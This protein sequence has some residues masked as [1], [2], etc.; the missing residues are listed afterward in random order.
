MNPEGLTPFCHPILSLYPERLNPES[1]WHGHIPF[2]FWITAA[3]QPQI[4]VEL[5]VY[6]ADSY[7]AFC[8]A[9]KYL[10]YPT[11]CYGID[12]WKGDE[13]T[14]PL[15]REQF[16]ELESY[17]YPRY[18]SFS[19]LLSF[20]FDEALDYFK[21]SSIDLLHIDGSSTYPSVRHNFEK[22][23]PKM[24]DR[25]IILIHGTNAREKEFGSWLYWEE[26]KESYPHFNFL[27]GHGLG[28]LAVGKDI[29]PSLK[30]LLS[31][32]KEE[33]DIVRSFFLRLG[34]GVAS[35]A[36]N[37]KLRKEKE[38]LL[39]KIR[40]LEEK[41]Q[42]SALLSLQL[43]EKE[44][45]AA[46]FFARLQQLEDK[47]KEFYR[48]LGQLFKV[49]PDQSADPLSLLALVKEKWEEEQALVASLTNQLR[50]VEKE[51]E[52]LLRKEEE[53]KNK[54]KA[55]ACA[56]K[57]VLENPLKPTQDTS[58]V[59]KLRVVV[60]KEPSGFDASENLKK[61]QLNLAN[62]EK[63]FHTYQN[64]LI[65]EIR[66]INCLDAKRLEQQY[67]SYKKSAK[68]NSFFAC[69]FSPKA[70][71]ENKLF[72]K[73]LELNLFDPDFYI[74]Q[75]PDV[76]REEALRHY[77]REGYIADLNPNPYFDTA[78]YVKQNPEVVQQKINPLIH[79]IEKGALNRRNPSPYF[80]IQYYLEQY[81]EVAE[82]NLNPLSHFLIQGRKE[83]RLSRPILKISSRIRPNLMLKE[84]R[85]T[86]IC[87]VCGKELPLQSSE[88]T[89]PD[90]IL[91]P[92]C[93]SK[94]P[95]IELG[96]TLIQ[97][98]GLP[99]S[100]LRE[101]AVKLENRRILLL[102]PIQ[103]IREVLSPSSTTE[104]F[105][106]FDPQKLA[107]FP[108]EYF[109]LVL[110]LLPENF[111]LQDK[112]PFEGI[113]ERLK[114]QAQFLLSFSLLGVSSKEPSNEAQVQCPSPLP[115]D[116]TSQ[117]GSPSSLAMQILEVLKECGFR[118]LPSQ[119]AAPP[120]STPTV[121]VLEKPRLAEEKKS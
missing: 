11:A 35:L 46:D 83:G 89:P 27:H 23:L 121:V 96:K 29:H 74:L 66:R 82:Q 33:T 84:P 100:S 37:E 3:V 117:N 104:F 114:P 7:C 111:S 115:T 116:L 91:C 65:E 92:Y 10:H 6:K 107:S 59:E 5:G 106:D 54:S 119:P 78:Y 19:K 40:E 4:F 81:P 86:R 71:E 80:D 18:G 56:E 13:T 76:S 108:K 110:G 69:L 97:A 24:T 43:K 32:E 98:L 1:L 8:Q 73:V 22:W 26:I 16:E 52:D 61:V 45:E 41:L 75:A 9:V 30:A 48:D 60:E 88:K 118:L 51:K 57:T 39:S 77:F 34:E 20:S 105:T 94:E 36:K 44:K 70:R 79:F 101:A 58:A 93:R 47:E 85:P 17:H 21:D 25:G 63:E 99:T 42:E 112:E 113:F 109:D 50:Q 55:A 68:K 49:S 95:E 14:P 90:P 102:G 72:E 31:L 28:V 64:R 67:K 120:P 103:A 62:L 53:E 87:T 15:S 38:S 12:H 2:A